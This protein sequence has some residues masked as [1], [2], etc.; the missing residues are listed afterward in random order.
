MSLIDE[1][2][3]LIKQHL[4]V[5]STNIDGDITFVSPAFCFMSGFSAKDVL[6]KNFS[7]IDHSDGF[8]ISHAALWAN[9]CKGES[10]NGELKLVKKNQGHFRVLASFFPYYKDDSRTLLAGFTGVMHEIPEYSYTKS[11][12]TNWEKNQRLAEYMAMIDSYVITSSTDIHG[13]ITFVSSAFCEISGYTKEELIGQ[14]HNIVRHPDMPDE[15]YQDLWSTI[16]RGEEWKGEI[17]NLKKNGTHYWVDVNIKPNRDETGEVFGY[18]AI[19]Q[20]ITGKKYIEELT[21]KD[22]LTGA[23]NRRFYNQVLENQI[24]RARR[25]KVWLGFLMVDAD[26][27]KKYNDSYGH[28]AGDEVLK[29]ITGMLQN[30]FRRGGDYVFRLGGEEFAVLYETNTRDQLVLMAQRSIKAMYDLNIE[31]TG[32][33]PFK[34]VTLSMGLMTLDPQE[35]YIMEELYKYADEALYR[36]KQNGR[37]CIETVSTN[38]ENV[39]LF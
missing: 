24:N 22:E 30:T 14:N 33:T 38:F 23:F 1:H 15:L 18:T 8:Q 3:N 28:L 7:S 17:K 31:H 25:N 34:R 6:K 10:W 26:N 16:Q 32:N 12:D 29:S 19:R 9:L 37:N 13:T 2:S 4:I 36:A 21:T 27:F 11:M 20:D 5:V 35:S 39:E